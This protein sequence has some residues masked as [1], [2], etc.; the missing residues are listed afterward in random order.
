MTMQL[1]PARPVG[2][3][4]RKSYARRCREGFWDAFIAGGAVLDI[5]YRGGLADALPIV[6]G[7]V[8][9]ELDHVR[10]SDDRI[11]PWASSGPNGY[12]G[13]HLPANDGQMD[14]VYASHV[15]EHVPNPQLSLAEWH[16]VLRIGGTMIVTVPSAYLYERRLTVPPSRFSSEHLRSFTPGS[17][18]ELVETA[19]EPNSYRVAALFDDDTGYDY[20]LPIEQHPTG[21]LEI[22]CVIRKI[23]KPQWNVEP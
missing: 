3:E 5:G 20:S 2:Y 18:L 22:V 14:T 15:L 17:L 8:G 21:V 7:A 23:A 19:L 11:E 16:R 1:D 4:S 6:P 9:I 10:I 13:L 12:D